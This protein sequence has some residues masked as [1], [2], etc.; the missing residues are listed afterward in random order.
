LSGIRNLQD[1]QNLWLFTP[2]LPFPSKS[3]PFEP[4]GRALHVHHQEVRHTVYVPES[5]LT[6]THLAFLQHAAA[7]VLVI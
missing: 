3:D 2:Y 6:T 4:L 7:A 1:A 5:G